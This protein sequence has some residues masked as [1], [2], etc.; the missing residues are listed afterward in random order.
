[1]QTATLHFWERNA[2]K[3]V[4]TEIRLPVFPCHMDISMAG[5]T[6]EIVIDEETAPFVKE[7]LR[8]PCSIPLSQKWQD[9]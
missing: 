4:S 2:M 1:M 3:S 7:L 6:P 8:L 9:T 5:G